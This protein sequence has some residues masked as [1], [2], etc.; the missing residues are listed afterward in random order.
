MTEDTES[1]TPKVHALR[2][3]AAK[4]IGNTRIS[5][6]LV[7]LEGLANRLLD[8]LLVHEA[9]SI[10]RFISELHPSPRAWFNL[11]AA[12]RMIGE[13]A[14]AMQ[15][16][17]SALRD[18]PY[19][20]PAYHLIGDL[21]DDAK[22]SEWL[23]S[24]EKLLDSAIL[25]SSEQAQLYYAIGQF[26]HKLGDHAGAFSRFSSGAAMLRRKQIYRVEDDIETLSAL[27]R[28]H[29]RSALELMKAGSSDRV[30]TFICGM[31]RSGTTLVEQLILRSLGTP[32][33]EPRDFSIALQQ[34][35]RNELSP[36]PRT[37]G[38]LA[39]RLLELDANQLGAA[40]LGLISDIA[41]P[42][43]H[44]VDKA[45]E[46]YISAGL[47][48]RAL[49]NS[50]VILV[51]RSARDRLASIYRCYFAGQYRYAL[52]PIDL[53][54]YIRSFD[55]LADHWRDNLDPE[56][57]MEVQYE[58]FV[59]SPADQGR[60]IFNFLGL[61]REIMNSE[62]STR[63]TLAVSASATQIRSPISRNSI[64]AWQCYEPWLQDALSLL[65]D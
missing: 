63:Q 8:H 16:C 10:L 2:S 42:G 29:S 34:S 41:G 15:W 52:D 13:L 23:A 60:I 19:F 24:A 61:D 50:R 27:R 58:E 32:L 11:A 45:L 1:V 44:F 51:R 3:E 36:T 47:I 14:E 40:Y 30:G 43:S 21:G 18:D 37:R 17:E 57:F 59:Q 49:P 31:P 53:A 48:T 6:G 64:A 26:K 54:R 39:T 22:C 5:H 65:N 28:T 25:E 35:W 56:K 4:L 55:Q 7:E 62:T 12:L 46:N 20:A 38:E 9:V 33:G